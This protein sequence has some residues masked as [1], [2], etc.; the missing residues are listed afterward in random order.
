MKN[1]S[2]V[3]PA[4]IRQAM[5]LLEKGFKWEESDEGDDFWMDVYN[6]LELIAEARAA[7]NA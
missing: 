7:T 2:S 1:P 6:K 3:D 5:S 4:A